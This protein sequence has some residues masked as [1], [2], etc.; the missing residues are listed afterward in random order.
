MCR[1]QSMEIQLKTIM[2]F[3]NYF[4]VIPGFSV[5][6]NAISVSLLFQSDFMTQL[7]FSWVWTGNNYSYRFKYH[8]TKNVIR[9]LFLWR[10]FTSP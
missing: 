1:F 5:M 4:Q 2:L 10:L 8:I 3:H 9:N 7:Y 6:L